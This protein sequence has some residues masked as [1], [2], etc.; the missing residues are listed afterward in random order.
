MNIGFQDGYMLAVIIIGLSFLCFILGLMLSEVNR[1]KGITTF[2]LS[3][4]LFAL[5]VYYYWVT[6]LCQTMPF[7]NNINKMNYYM[8]V[9]KHTPAMME[10]I[11]PQIPSATQKGISKT[12]PKSK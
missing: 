5:G 1:G 10:P 4:I 12:M 6:G 2:I 3:V 9:Y 8:H 11:L 7:K